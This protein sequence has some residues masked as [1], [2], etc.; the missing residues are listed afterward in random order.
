MND[1]IREK[2]GIALVVEK[3]VENKLKWFAHAERRRV[4]AVVRRV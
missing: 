3:L 2:V 1:T 4:N